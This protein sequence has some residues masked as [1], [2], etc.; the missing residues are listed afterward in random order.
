[1][2]LLIG[3]G[4]FTAAARGDGGP[5]PLPVGPNGLPQI[6]VDWNSFAPGQSK[7]LA[8]KPAGGIGWYSP[9][10]WPA[11]IIEPGIIS[12]SSTPNDTSTA[13]SSGTA[14][15]AGETFGCTATAYYPYYVYQG[16]IEGNEDFTR[17]VN[18][19]STAASVGL[20]ESA[21]YHTHAWN[22]SYH[23][24]NS[25]WIAWSA[26]FACDPSRQRKWQTVTMNEFTATDGEQSLWAGQ[27][28]WTP[29]GLNC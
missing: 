24:S 14:T 8:V 12:I 6:A 9:A 16:A 3:I 1:M 18:V 15:A 17:C 20:K 25:Y 7:L 19:F 13:T 22:D 5:I 28:P 27:S 26:A 4:A 21:T 23:E 29:T 10:D 11:T 2:A